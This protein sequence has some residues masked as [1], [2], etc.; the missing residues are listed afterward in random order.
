MDSQYV[1]LKH[2]AAGHAGTL[3]DKDGILVFKPTVKQEI[4]FLKESQ[5]RYY[6]DTITESTD[7]DSTEVLLGAWMPRYLGIIEEGDKKSSIDGSISS[8]YSIQR[9]KNE[10]PIVDSLVDFDTD[11]GNSSANDNVTM[12]DNNEKPFIVLEN[13]LHGYSKPNIMDIKLGKILYDENAS[14]EKKIRLQEVSDS[15]TSGSMGFRIC[16]MKLQK[17]HLISTVSK[18]HFELDIIEHDGE[19]IEYVFLNKLYGRTRTPENIQEAFELYFTNNDLTEKRK[20]QLITMFWQ[21]LQLFYNTLLDEEI[22]L[23]SSS[24]LFV[25]EGDPE[26]WDYN[27]DEDLLLKPDFIDKEVDSDD[28]DNGTVEKERKYSDVLSSMSLIDFAHSKFVPGEGY[29][30]NIIEG[31]EALLKIF[32]EMLRQH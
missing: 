16:G 6:K 14:P 31:V 22:R 8:V 17:N 4:D 2:Q 9:T 23:I 21:R 26:H 10:Q 15:T 18:D 32:E 20:K 11:E 13:L 28:D 30:V 27:Q 7:Q 29:D 24:L 25:Y 1:K 5:D 3:S 19:N 12:K